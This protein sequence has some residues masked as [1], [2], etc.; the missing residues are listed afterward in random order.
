ML[1]DDAML[2]IAEITLMSAVS[3]FLGRLQRE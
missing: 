3:F 1:P 2:Q